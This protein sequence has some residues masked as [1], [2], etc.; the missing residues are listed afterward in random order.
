MVFHNFSL[1]IEDLPSLNHLKLE[2][3]SRLNKIQVNR[4][5]TL[6]TLDVRVSKFL[7]FCLVTFFE[8]CINY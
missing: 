3:C 1:L 8:L 5:Q 4:I 2:S 6:E 7:G